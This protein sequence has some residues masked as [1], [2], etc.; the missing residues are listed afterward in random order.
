MK[1]K[2]ILR[3][4]PSLSKAGFT[5]VQVTYCMDI[6]GILTKSLTNGTDDY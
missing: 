3:V 2:T 6:S 4:N 5:M 1:W